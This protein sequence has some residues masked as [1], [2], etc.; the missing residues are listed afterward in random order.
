MEQVLEVYAR[1]DD[2]RRP[3]VCFDEASKELHADAHPPQP[4]APGRAA[5]EDCRY[6]RQGTANLFMLVCPR[7]GWR[8]VT[9]TERRTKVDFAHQMKELV[10]VHFPDADVVTVVQDNLNTHTK[11]AL[12]EAFPAAEAKRIADRLEFVSTPTHASWLN[13]AEC[14]WSVLQRQCL[15]RRIAT[16]DELRQ[17]VGA[18]VQARNAARVMIHWT[19]RLPDARIKLAHLYPAASL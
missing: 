8:A 3:Q 12:Y 14:E 13:M 16:A 1:P 6:E 10:D 2:P 7:R 19:F 15:G 5:R 17:Q 11:G 18:W 9:V 4:A